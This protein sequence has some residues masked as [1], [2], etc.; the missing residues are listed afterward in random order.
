MKQ[1]QVVFNAGLEPGSGGLR[2]WHADHSAMMPPDNMRCIYRL[3]K[4]FKNI[5][6]VSQKAVYKAQVALWSEQ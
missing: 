2:D 3:L 6:F 5:D 4:L 1:I